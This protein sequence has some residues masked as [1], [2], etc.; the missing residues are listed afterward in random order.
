MKNHRRFFFFA[1]FFL[2]FSG[3]FHPAMATTIDFETLSDGTPLQD[4]DDVRRNVATEYAA[5]GVTFEAGGSSD[6]AVFNASRRMATAGLPDPPVGNAWF[7]TSKARET[8]STFYLDTLFSSGVRS[9]AGDVVVNYN[10]SVT[11]TAY[12]S[13]DGVIASMTFPSQSDLPLEDRTWFCGSFHFLSVE[14]I[15]RIRLESSSPYAVG[16][17][18]D[19]LV[20]DPV[21]EPGTVVLFGCGLL[22]LAVT[23]RKPTPGL[24]M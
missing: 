14:A 23:G 24:E 20:F 19:N 16:A 1:M 13:L 3:V 11:A 22:C 15:H 6:N 4:P 9:A 21:P 10:Y 12:N 5:L 8:G 18:L 2:F 17:G 7:I